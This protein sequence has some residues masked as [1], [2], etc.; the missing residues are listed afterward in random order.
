MIVRSENF[1]KKR[2]RTTVGFSMDIKY[3]CEAVYIRESLA[4]QDK[5]IATWLRC[6]K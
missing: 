1:Q 3:E 4:S 2:F 5:V 6:E